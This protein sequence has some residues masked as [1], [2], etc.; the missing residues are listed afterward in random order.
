MQDVFV[1][2]TITVNGQPFEVSPPARAVDYQTLYRLMAENLPGKERMTVRI[3]MALRWV[4]VQT[5][6]DV[7]RHF[8]CHL[9][10]KAG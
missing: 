9:T 10:V 6:E 3:P 8:P 4:R 2:G 1:T 7:D 5:W